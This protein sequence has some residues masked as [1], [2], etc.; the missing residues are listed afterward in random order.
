MERL[1]KTSDLIVA[2]NDFEKQKL[3]L[4]KEKFGSMELFHIY[5]KE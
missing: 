4:I 3:A 5:S 2:R 1:A